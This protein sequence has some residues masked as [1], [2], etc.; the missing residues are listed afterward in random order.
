MYWLVTYHEKI[1]ANPD[2]FCFHPKLLDNKME[3]AVNAVS[4]D[5]A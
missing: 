3:K 1:I 5:F 4:W 2:D